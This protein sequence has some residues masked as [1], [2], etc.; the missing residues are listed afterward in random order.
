MRAAAAGARVLRAAGPVDWGGHVAWF[1]D[2]D[3]HLWE[4]V[5]NP[6]LGD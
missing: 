3:G 6:K 1:A 2:P 5:F 4:L